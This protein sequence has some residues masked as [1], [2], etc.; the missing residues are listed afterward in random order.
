MELPGN[1]TLTSTQNAERKIMPNSWRIPRTE[2]C[3]SCKTN[4]KETDYERCG[5]SLGD[6]YKGIFYDYMCH[7][8]KY[9]GRWVY[10]DETS[11]P[12]I[13]LHKVIKEITLPPE[14]PKETTAERLNSMHSIDDLLRGNNAK[15][16]DKDE[17]KRRPS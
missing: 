1:T 13:L 16:H 15:D 10:T 14:E 17:K 11:S 9:K 12:I 2:K 4:L 5:V 8:C 6:D 7:R 3:P